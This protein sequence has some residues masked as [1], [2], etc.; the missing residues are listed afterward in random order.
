MP[1]KRSWKEVNRHPAG[2]QNYLPVD[3]TNYQESRSYLSSLPIWQS[4]PQ[5]MAILDETEKN[6]S[7]GES[8]E[9]QD[10]G[11]RILHGL[12]L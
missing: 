1:V 6:M 2:Q 4:Y 5:T 8:L 12:M 10:L 3:I 9:I 7:A 11:Y